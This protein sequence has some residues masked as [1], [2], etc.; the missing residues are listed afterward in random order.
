[1]KLL[2]WKGEGGGGE[3]G[4]GGGGGG[5][6]EEERRCRGEEPNFVAFQSQEINIIVPSNTETKLLL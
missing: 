4:G 6:G 2:L 1:V 3:G 5:G